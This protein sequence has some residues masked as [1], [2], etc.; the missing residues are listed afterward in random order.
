MKGAKKYAEEK[1]G[2]SYKEKIPPAAFQSPSND[3]RGWER[4]LQIKLQLD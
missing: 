3:E 1:A 2:L 4:A